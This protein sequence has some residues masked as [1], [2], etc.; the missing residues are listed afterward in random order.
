[1]AIK[2][3][4]VEQNLNLKCEKCGK[5]LKD[6]VAKFSKSKYGKELC[7][8]CQNIEKNLPVPEKEI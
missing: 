1:M 5:D 6:N 7:F 4:E 3:Q 2:K 8:D